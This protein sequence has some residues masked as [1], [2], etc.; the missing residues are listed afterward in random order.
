MNPRII[1][2]NAAG[3]LFCMQ[4]DPKRVR[5]M[6][7]SPVWLQL[8]LDELHTCKA[9]SNVQAIEILPLGP[10][11]TIKWLET[12]GN[13][14]ENPPI[15]WEFEQRLED[16]LQYT[17]HP[18]I[19]IDAEAD[20]RAVRRCLNDWMGDSEGPMV[21]TMQSVEAAQRVDTYIDMTLV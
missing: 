3:D 20:R 21:L 7:N 12:E 8:L 17:D 9:I 11:L 5:E 1:I 18:L 19:R 4:L 10:E 2:E 14:F 16:A 6:L 13:E 15:S